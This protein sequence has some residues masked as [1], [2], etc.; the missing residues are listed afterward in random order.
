[1]AL[2]PRWW[3]T[4]TRAPPFPSRRLRVGERLHHGLVHVDF[5]TQRRT[6]KDSARYFSAV[7]ASNA[8]PNDGSE[9]VRQP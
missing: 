8:I 9:S 5:A 4:A 3:E 1:M 7:A 6:S 2:K